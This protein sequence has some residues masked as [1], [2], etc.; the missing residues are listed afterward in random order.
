[1]VMCPTHVA[2][3]AVLRRVSFLMLLKESDRRRAPSLKGGRRV[4]Y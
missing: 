4:M 2:A 3:F 1:V